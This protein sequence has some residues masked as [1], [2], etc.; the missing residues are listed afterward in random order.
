MVLTSMPLQA[1]G[2][3]AGGLAGDFTKLHLTIHQ[4]TISTEDDI[5]ALEPGLYEFVVANKTNDK[6]V[7]EIQDFKTEK[8]LGKIKIKPSKSKKARV[9]ITKNGFRYRKSDD[10]WHDIEVK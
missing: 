2:G 10:I 7:F 3:G 1:G 5:A 9:K 4:D 8:V 6:V